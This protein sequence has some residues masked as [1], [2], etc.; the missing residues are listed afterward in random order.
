VNVPAGTLARPLSGEA[1]GMVVLTFA[2]AGISVG[3]SRIVFQAA[4]ARY[5]SASS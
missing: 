4:L 2:A 3:L 1:W 5:R